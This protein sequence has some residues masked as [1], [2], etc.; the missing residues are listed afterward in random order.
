MR[1]GRTAHPPSPAPRGLQ[2]WLAD[3]GAG[4][5]TRAQGAADGVPGDEQVPMDTNYLERA[6]RPI[7]LGRKNWLFCWTEI[8]AH[9]AG[10][11]QS[12]ITTCRLHGIEPY[13][14][15]VDVLQRVA[16][17]PSSR[18]GCG[19]ST[20]PSSRCARTCTASAD[21]QGTGYRERRFIALG[22]PAACGSALRECWS[23]TLSKFSSL[24]TR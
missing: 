8:G 13:T 14:Y 7:P 10:I 19:S 3:P 1:C 20:S 11:V 9:H 17:S 18:R 5:R 2:G 6:L 16:V 21:R 23:T 15:F 22:P 12:L 4:L 24:R